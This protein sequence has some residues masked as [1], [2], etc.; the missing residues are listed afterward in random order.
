MV[1]KRY[2]QGV[3][4]KISCGAEL[5]SKV[6]Q[7]RTIG[8]CTVLV[9]LCRVPLSVSQSLF[10]K[11]AG[12]ILPAQSLLH[13]CKVDFGLLWGRLV[14]GEAAGCNNNKGLVSMAMTMSLKFIR[15]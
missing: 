13:R 5:V 15:T 14:A 6:G 2:T 8:A 9:R 7:R 12:Q 3:M 4:D 1:K 11:M 10:Q